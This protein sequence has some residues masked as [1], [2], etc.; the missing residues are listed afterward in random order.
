MTINAADILGVTR[1]VTKKWTKQRKSEERGSR[2]R[3][4]RAYAYSDRVNFTDIADDI[5]PGAYDHASGGGKYTVSQRQLYYAC[6][7]AFKNEAGREL[8]AKYFSN[9]L[10]RQYLNRHPDETASWKVTA[11]PRGTLTIPN[12]KSTVRIPCG[13]IAIDKHLRSASQTI[14]KGIEACLPIE[15]PSVR[16]GQRYQAVLYI[17]KEGFEPLL[18]EARIAERFDLAILSCKGQSVVAARRFV[19][20]VCRVDGGVPLFVAHDFDKAGFEISQRLTTVSDWARLNDRVAYR[21]QNKINVTDLGLRLADVEK[22]ALESESVSFSG[23]FAR[24][25]IATREEQAFLRTGR[26]VELNAFTSPQF[27]EWLET[28]LMAN[29]LGNRLIPDDGVLEAAYRRAVATAY[30]NDALKDA[31]EDGQRKADDATIPKALKR[32]LR[33][34]M[35]DSPDEPWDQA[36]Y[37]LVASDMEVD[38]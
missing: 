29:G 25:S 31:I 26:R 33:E 9:T 2:S 35:K 15:W 30:V 5:L 13:T 3:Y 20:E 23:R 17:E 36:L 1:A 28:K 34:A 19:D 24:D 8:E 10:L 7:E 16:H 14:D 11:D 12:S 37:S 27:I 38:E 22:Y 21:F 32:R 4:S 6:R 18:E